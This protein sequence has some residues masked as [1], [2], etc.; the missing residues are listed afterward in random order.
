MTQVEKI[1]LLKLLYQYRAIGYDY[2]EGYRSAFKDNEQNLPHNLEELKTN[3]SKCF[4]C[5][6]CKSRKNV[7]FGYGN[8]KAKVMFLGDSPSIS[9][10]ELGMPFSGKSGE[11]LGKIIESVLLVSKEDVYTTTI[12]KCKTPENRAPTHEEIACCKPYLIQQIQ[13]IKPKVIVTLG[14]VAYQNLTGD[15]DMLI[16][17]IRGSVLNFGDAKLIPTLHTNFLL[18]NPSAKKEV[19]ADMLKVRSML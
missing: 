19:Y 13:T 15:F 11:L 2:F 10:D 9:E 1:G 5:G 14:E 18:R 7:V 8:T 17:K 12:L 4:L 6:L 16:G 3:V